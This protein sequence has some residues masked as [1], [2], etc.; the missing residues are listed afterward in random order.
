MCL[1]WPERVGPQHWR[2]RVNEGWGRLVALGAVV[3]LFWG[4][5]GA[6]VAG[7]AA[8]IWLS[9]GASTTSVAVWV[10]AAVA[11]GLLLASAGL[12]VLVCAAALW[13]DAPPTR[14]GLDKPWAPMSSR[15]RGV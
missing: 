11:G 6:G 9:R 1:S 10:V 12:A 2:G 8:V 14:R 3:S 5:S 7:V 4:A 15:K 13:R